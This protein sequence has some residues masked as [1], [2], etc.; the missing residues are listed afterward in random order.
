MKYKGLIFDLDGTLLDS[1]IDIVK[2]TNATIHAMGGEMI[3]EE[4]IASYVGHGV[5]ALLYDALKDV[6][7][8]SKDKALAF[9]TEYYMAHSLDHS[10][11]FAGVEEFLTHWRGQNVKCAI[12][13]NKP[14]EYTDPIIAGL[15]KG[16]HF[17]HVIGAE[18]P[19]PKKPEPD[20]I[21]H[22]VKEWGMMAQDVMY[23]GDTDVD[24]K[25]GQNAGCDVALFLKGLTP[26]EELVG[27]KDQARLFESFE[28]LTDHLQTTG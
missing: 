23:V 4:E 20:A 13:T 11:F 17:T 9:F 5:R 28:E 14:Q 16:H 12:V 25:A 2:A 19:F 22:I 3:D 10:D 15:D 24:L 8:I 27:F 21:L 18:G 6:P 7:G 26:S 1:R